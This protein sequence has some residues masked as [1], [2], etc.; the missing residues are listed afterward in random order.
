MTNKLKGRLVMGI[1]L[2]ATAVPAAIISG[3]MFHGLCG[4]DPS[5]AML[6][7]FLLGA[8]AN[9]V[10]M[11]G[12]LIANPSFRDDFLQRLQEWTS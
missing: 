5:G 11:V 10:L 1:G 2:A 4:V 7:C 8:G 9:M 3:P 12:S 6:A